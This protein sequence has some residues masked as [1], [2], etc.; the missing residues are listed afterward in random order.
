MAVTF[1]PPS[2]DHRVG[3]RFDTVAAT[4][5]YALLA[6]SRSFVYQA[7]QTAVHAGP[8]PWIQC[9]GTGGSC[10]GAQCADAAWPVVTCAGDFTCQRFNSFYWQCGKSRGACTLSH[11]HFQRMC[12]LRHVCNSNTTWVCFCLKQCAEP[13]GIKHVL[14][15]CRRPNQ[16]DKQRLCGDRADRDI[17]GRRGG[18]RCYSRSRNSLSCWRGLHLWFWPCQL[19]GCISCQ[20]TA[21]GMAWQHISVRNDA[22]P[23]PVAASDSVHHFSAPV[24]RLL[25]DLCSASAAAPTDGSTASPTAAPSAPMV[26]G[27]D[28]AWKQCGACHPP[29]VAKSSM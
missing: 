20:G 19:C 26:A 13:A 3:F 15:C 7:R 1:Q 8:A 14:L 21:A 10:T 18:D 22:G 28:N 29:H 25:A 11:P 9:G 5:S 23:Q 17:Q 12:T 4:T 6:V 2:V 24:G 27:A 16:G